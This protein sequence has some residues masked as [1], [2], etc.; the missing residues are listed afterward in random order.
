MEL[1]TR[2][3][4]EGAHELP[5][6]V[7]RFP[8]PMRVA[9][10]TP[11]G[12]GLGVRRWAVNAQVPP[13]YAR[14]DPD[15][16]LHKLA[17]SLGLPGRGVG[18]MT[19]ADVRKHEV[20]HDGGVDVVATVGLGQPILAAAP[21]DRR[22]RQLVGTINVVAVVPERLS[23]AA[24]VNA[25]ATVTEAKTQAL[26]DLGLHATGTATDAVCVVCPDEG[27]PAA[28]GGPRSLWGARLARAVHGAVLAGA[29]R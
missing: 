29:R 6:L 10:G 3:R 17:V 20:A 7:W 8:N 25:V 21:D 4:R 12:G 14:R 5:V 28:F 19:A 9:A 27:R 26:L 13:E 11:H 23:D 18:M 24:L 15:H 2:L 22:A 16:H 1:Q